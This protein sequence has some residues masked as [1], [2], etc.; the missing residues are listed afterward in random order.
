MKTFLFLLALLVASP[1]FAGAWSKNCQF[2]GTTAG[3]V[4]TALKPETNPVIGAGARGCY[5][6]ISTDTGDYGYVTVSSESALLCFDPDL[7]DTATSAARLIPHFCPQ[8]GPVDTANPL[9]SCIAMGG[10]SANT[11]LD[12]TEGPPASQNACMTIGTGVYIF[13]TSVDCAGGDTC[14]ISIQGQTVK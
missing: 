10:A 7:F 6:Y 1:A 4:G 11:N 5:R 9:Q 3:V 8:G 14:Q 2:S 12:G 13:E